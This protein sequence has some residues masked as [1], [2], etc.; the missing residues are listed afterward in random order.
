MR[1]T[2]LKHMRATNQ[3]HVQATDLLTKN[4]H[5]QQTKSKHALLTNLLE[6][7]VSSRLWLLLTQT[8][9]QTIDSW[10]QHN[11]QPATTATTYVILVCHSTCSVHR[12]CVRGNVVSLLYLLK[13]PSGLTTLKK[14]QFGAEDLAKTQQLIPSLAHYP[15]A[16]LPHAPLPP[17]TTSLLK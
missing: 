6:N 10:C 17:S 15:P 5:A 3:K 16:P 11:I 9:A 14:E 4:T 2:R 7:I 1:A 13:P 12:G 8:T